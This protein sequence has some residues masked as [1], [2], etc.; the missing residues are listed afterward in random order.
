[1]DDLTPNAY[2]GAKCYSSPVF[3]VRIN[4]S[5]AKKLQNVLLPR[6]KLGFDPITCC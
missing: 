5:T 6:L 1:M 2:Y 3:K 4:L